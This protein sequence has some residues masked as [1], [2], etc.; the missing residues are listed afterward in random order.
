MNIMGISQSYTSTGVVVMNSDM[1]VIYYQSITTN[2]R[3]DI[4]QRAYH[5]AEIIISIAHQY[6]IDRFVIE[7]CPASQKELV[8]LQ[9]TII[10]MMRNEGFQTYNIHETIPIKNRNLTLLNTL[11]EDTRTKF[12]STHSVSKGLFDITSAYW[13]T[14]YTVKKINN[15]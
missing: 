2:K 15:S 5:T 6:K 11:N 12:K 9:F 13:L 7:S 3:F 10:N 8:G 4:Y 14:N 1:E